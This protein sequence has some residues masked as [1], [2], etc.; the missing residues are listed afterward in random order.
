VAMLPSLQVVPVMRWWSPHYLYVPFAF[1]AML[2]AEVVDR[3]WQRLRPFALAA[4]GVLAS[5]AAVDGLHY[6]SDEA[7]WT[8][9][10][11]ADP[12]CR[13]AQFYLAEVAREGRRLDDAAQLYEKAIATAPNVVSYVDELPARQNL[14]VVRLEQGDFNAASAAFRGAL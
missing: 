7:L 8:R 2:I 14:G 11:R 1:A 6:R 5:V 4:A 13:E 3:R 10:A 9:E 12:A